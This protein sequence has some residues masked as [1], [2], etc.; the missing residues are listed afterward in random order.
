MKK[1]E[2]KHL[3]PYLPYKLKLLVVSKTFGINTESKMEEWLIRD[4]TQ[5]FVKRY[6]VKSV[7]P[8]L[9]PLLDLTKEIEVNGDK[10]V[11]VEKMKRMFGGHNIYLGFG[12]VVLSL[13]GASGIAITDYPLKFN[14][15]LFEWHFDVFGLIENDLAI[16]INTL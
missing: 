13:N 3:A 9:R 16:D 6:R 14:S 2:L 8:I 5:P 11:P 12:G 15:L 4:A 1:L 10:F 7:K